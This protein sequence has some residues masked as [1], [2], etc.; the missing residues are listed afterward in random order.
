[1]GYKRTNGCSVSSENISPTAAATALPSEY[2]NSLLDICNDSKEGKK[3]TFDTDEPTPQ[4]AQATAT[5]ENPPTKRP[6]KGMCRL[7]VYD[8]SDEAMIS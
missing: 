1:M 3:C 8:L 6:Q 5:I 7:S 2:L 4:V